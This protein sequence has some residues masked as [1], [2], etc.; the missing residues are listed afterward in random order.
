[1]ENQK[2]P[3]RPRH[4]HEGPDD[5]LAEKKIKTS[6]M[7]ISNLYQHAL[8]SI[9]AFMTLAG[10]ASVAAVN[11]AWN[12]AVKSMHTISACPPFFLDDAGM[13]NMCASSSLARHIGSFHR[14]ALA[15]DG[16]FS[17]IYSR[18]PNVKSVR[19]VIADELVGPIHFSLSLTYLHL[20][21]PPNMPFDKI[22][23]VVQTASRL[24]KL[25]T[26]HLNV[27]Q[28]PKSICDGIILSPFTNS[29]S[30]RVLTMCSP[31]R[32][33]GDQ[34]EH[35]RG[36]PH[37]KCMSGPLSMDEVRVLLKKPHALQLESFDV[38]SSEN[39][40]DELSVFL[41]DLPALV[42]LSLE[43][44][45]QVSFLF[46]CSVPR[47]KSLKLRNCKLA[48]DLQLESVL[49]G[50]LWASLTDLSI[51]H[52]PN[53]N[54]SHVRELVSHMPALVRLYLTFLNQLESLD[55]L[56]SDSLARNLVHLTIGDCFLLNASDLN[57]IEP[58]KQLEHLSIA[59]PFTQTLDGWSKS[60]FVIPSR[61]FPKLGYVDIDYDD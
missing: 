41:A 15:T 61:L 21:M 2:T 12:S 50:R 51:T 4:F 14:S 9:F 52:L 42:E 35:Y 45:R 44:S 30:M 6:G 54:S 39:Y 11:H 27:W 10:L 46:L 55:C 5:G 26:M 32:L 40:D 22:N 23:H 53:I 29:E 3:K 57:Y 16:V 58:L 25:H 17:L 1:M 47:L 31:F 49:R 56:D 36:I 34:L 33:T 8:E 37:L 28:S 38:T 24:T 7:M 60:K 43:K 13:E 20:C 18:L 59:C 48:K 19:C